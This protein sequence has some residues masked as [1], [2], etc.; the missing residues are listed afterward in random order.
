[1]SASEYNAI[2]HM[3]R[4]HKTE[5]TVSDVWRRI[6]GTTSL[7]SL[8]GKKLF[9]RDELEG[10]RRYGRSITGLDP[11]LEDL[12]VTVLRSP[13]RPPMKSTAVKLSLGEWYLL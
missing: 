5:V 1:M 2:S 8:V 12:G 6:N 10:L 7:G 9:T 11:L 13:R 4:A 3:L